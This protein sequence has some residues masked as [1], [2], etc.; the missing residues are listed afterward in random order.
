[1]SLLEKRKGNPI[2]KRVKMNK[3]TGE[4][5]SCPCE[6]CRKIRIDATRVVMIAD[7]MREEKTVEEAAKI[8]NENLAGWQGDVKPIIVEIIREENDS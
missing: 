4:K 8:V 2:Q 6:K 1:M 7:L 5:I 3:C